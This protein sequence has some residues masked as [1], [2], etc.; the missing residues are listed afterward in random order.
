MASYDVLVWVQVDDV[1]D[2]DEAFVNVREV[3]DQTGLEYE[4]HDA[5]EIEEDEEGNE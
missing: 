3:L 5:V 1:L 4:I 2:D